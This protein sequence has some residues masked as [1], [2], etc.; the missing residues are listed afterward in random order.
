MPHEDCRLAFALSRR[1]LILIAYLLSL[2][3]SSALAAS[4]KPQDTSLLKIVT[5][6]QSA[7]CGIIIESKWFANAQKYEDAFQSLVK[8]VISDSTQIPSQ[9][10]FSHYGVL[11]ISMGQQ[12]TGGYSVKLAAEQMEVVDRRA[13]IKVLWTTK[14]PGM[15]AIQMLTNPCLLLEVP[16]GDYDFIDVVD[17]TGKTRLSVPLNEE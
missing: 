5:H 9:I 3:S 8:G 2:V 15:M 11:L 6:H 7:T 10:D 13:K 17:Q 14:K 12:R 1:S 16:K 4:G